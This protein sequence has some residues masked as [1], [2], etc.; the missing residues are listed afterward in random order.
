MRMRAPAIG[1]AMLVSAIALVAY[2]R[3]EPVVQTSPEPTSEPRPEQP[4]PRAAVG[5][6]PPAPPPVVAPPAEESPAPTAAAA[7]VG[8]APL[9]GESAATPMADLLRR[10]S[11]ELPAGIIEGEREFAAEAID[12]AWAPGAEADLLGKLAQ[13]NDL[14]II[15]VQVE[16]KSTMCRLQMTQPDPGDESPRF[17]VLVKSLGLEPRWGM[18]LRDESGALNSVAYLWREGY[19]PPPQP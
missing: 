12:L 5:E 7:D 2:F 9:P 1:V 4:P 17:N 11:A 16:C 3:P 18:A 8:R 6:S 10:R 15:D 14:E 19:G 13:D